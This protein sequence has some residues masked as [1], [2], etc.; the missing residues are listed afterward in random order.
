MRYIS[1]VRGE[2]TSRVYFKGIFDGRSDKQRILVIGSAK[3]DVYRRGGDSLQ[4]RY[5]LLRI[6]PLSVKELSGT[7]NVVDRLLKLGGF[8]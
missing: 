5:H 4:G 2:I 8:P 6:H 7:K 1:I 3:L